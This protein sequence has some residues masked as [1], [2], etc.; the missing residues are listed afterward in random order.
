M[1]QRIG[2]LIHLPGC[3]PV[4]LDAAPIRFFRKPAEHVAE[5]AEE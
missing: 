5:S 2:G 1:D 4:E 3:G